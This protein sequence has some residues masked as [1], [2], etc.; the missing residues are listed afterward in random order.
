MILRYEHIILLSVHM[1]SHVYFYLCV[2]DSW[3]IHN[4]TLFI[5]LETSE[6]NVRLVVKQYST[7]ILI[8]PSILQNIRRNTNVYNRR[9]DKNL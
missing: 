1:I 2:I 7:E 3:L 8:L 9:Y 6:L 4:I 5:H